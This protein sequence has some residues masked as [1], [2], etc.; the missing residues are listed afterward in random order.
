MVGGSKDESL[1]L[2]RDSLTPDP[3]PNHS[4]C[5]KSVPFSC[6]LEPF[7]ACLGCLP[8]L[9]QKACNY[10]IINLFIPFWCSCDNINLDRQITF[11]MG[12]HPAVADLDIM[13]TSEYVLKTH[14]KIAWV[15][16]WQFL[17]FWQSSALHN[18]EV[19]IRFHTLFWLCKTHKHFQEQKLNFRAYRV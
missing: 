14:Q 13:T 8:C 15:K 12:V 4:N 17:V 3:S 10:V 5:S 7:W 19:K 18:Q 9:P 11:W 2:C 16:F 1:C 6:C